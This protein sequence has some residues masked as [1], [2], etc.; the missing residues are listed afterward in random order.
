[1]SITAKSLGPVIQLSQVVHVQPGYLSRD[2]VRSAS[3]GTHHLLQGR[4]ISEN[5]GVQ[6]EGAI[7]FHPKRRPDLYRVSRG[8]VLVTARGRDHRA[9]YVHDNL[10]NVLAAA[11]F[12]ILRSDAGRILPGYLAWWLNLPGVQSAID[13]ESGGTDISYISRQALENLTIP[14]PE[15]KVQHRIERVV[16]L[17]RQRNVLRARIDEKREHYIRTLCELAVRRAKEKESES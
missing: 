3:D 7:R 11:T 4:D 17:W 16:V 12:Y 10:S 1:M 8:D 15:L 2:R 13:K 9:Y 14:V 6:V 5:H